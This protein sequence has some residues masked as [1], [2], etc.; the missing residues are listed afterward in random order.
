[1]DTILLPIQKYYANYFYSID[2]FSLL[3]S[4]VC[5]QLKRNE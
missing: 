2:Q 5:A 3:Y 1:M 4:V